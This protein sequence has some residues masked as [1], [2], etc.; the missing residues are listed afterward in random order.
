MSMVVLRI[1]TPRCIGSSV[2][3]IATKS[4]RILISIDLIRLRR[5]LLWRNRGWVK[6]Y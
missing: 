6:V 3:L 1:V 4:Q 2:C 5:K